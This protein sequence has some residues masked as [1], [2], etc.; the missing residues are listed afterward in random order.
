MKNVV[1]KIQNN[2]FQNNLFE[3]G[4]SLVLAVS[5]GP[6]SVF[7]AEIFAMLQKKY[8]L[9][10]ILA[11]VN[12]GL[13]GKESDRDQKIVEGLAEKYTWELFVLRPETKNKANLEE[14]LRK[15]R[16]DFF[17]K[18]REENSYDFIAVAHT[19]DDQV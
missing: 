10:I 15:I 14:N 17:K 7:L 2:I 4:A 6:D 12:Y 9:E 1:K 11:H 8:G 18:I 19:Q 16:Y 5:G 3:R 13:R